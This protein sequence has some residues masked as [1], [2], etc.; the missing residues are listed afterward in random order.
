MG[1]S[2]SGKSTVAL[3]CLLK[4]FDF[5]A[6]DG[7]FVAPRTMLATGVANFLHV[8]SDSVGWIERARDAA[9]IRR[10]PIIRRRSGVKKYEINLRRPE[11][12][13]AAQPPSIGAVIFLSSQSAGRRP[14]LRPLPKSDLVRKLAA[15]QA[16]AAN[17]PEWDVFVRNVSR[18]NV[19][20]LRRGRHPREAA[21]VLQALI[22]S[23]PSAA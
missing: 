17:Q 7:V 11:Y 16:Y 21:E 1:P 5:L 9:L 2:G 3:Q 22:G 8:R 4:G 18:L 20:E 6:E 15:E 12:R 23:L 19:F 14:L 13:L 10:S